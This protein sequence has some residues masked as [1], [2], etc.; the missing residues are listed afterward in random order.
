MVIEKKSL[1]TINLE[2]MEN[3]ATRQSN[4]SNYGS[5]SSK[6]QKNQDSTSPSNTLPT[7]GSNMASNGGMSQPTFQRRGSADIILEAAKLSETRAGFSPVKHDIRRNLTQTSNQTYNPI[8]NS[9][10]PASD[11]TQS[12]PQQR[13]QG[14][15]NDHSLEFQ[16][17]GD[18]LSQSIV[19]PPI[20]S[21]L[22]S[23]HPT[24]A[25]DPA[26][27][28]AP[29]IGGG[30][31]NTNQ[32]LQASSIATAS[33]LQANAYSNV[34][35]P[36]HHVATASPP[37][38]RHNIPHV[39]HDYAHVPDTIGFV[40]KKTGGVTQPFPEKLYEMLANESSPEG[41]VDSV[42]SW[43][44]H[45]RAFIVRKP[46]LFTSRVM[47]KYFRQTKLTSFQR[48]LNLYGFRRIT[49]G[50][51]TGAYY[52]ELFLRGRAQLCMRMV[53]Q[54]V[55]GTG[56]KQPTDV[57]SEPNFYT[58]PSLAD[59]QQQPPSAT[60]A[61]PIVRPTCGFS[62][63]A[64]AATST[65]PRDTIVSGQYGPIHDAR[66]PMS[67]GIHAAQLL[68]GMASAPIQS[69]PP[70]PDN[71]LMNGTHAT[72]GGGVMPFLSQRDANP[73]APGVEQPSMGIPTLAMGKQ[74][75]S[76]MYANKSTCV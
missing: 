53:R 52:H 23:H 10:T 54:K 63:M 45:G 49:Q 7:S 72:N 16:Q 29:G 5:S 69:L 55:K 40:R 71:V 26:F 3:P 18:S 42:V 28:T 61:S 59:L 15:Q 57:G 33:Q 50:A 48:Q 30:D 22:H 66:P 34:S 47:P 76:G 19:T 44:P 65:L 21:A 2:S 73:Q 32:Q 68:K 51:A 17:H 35:F 25:M 70:L 20:A 24:L 27:A 6:E 41:D 56:H 1:K 75:N 31:M 14:R 67:P 74:T 36:V 9:A 8:S 39:Y 12:R 38:L 37:P 4:K 46:K 60:P 43:L 64:M 13:V 11:Q 58:M 62:T